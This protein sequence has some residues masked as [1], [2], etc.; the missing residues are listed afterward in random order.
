MLIRKAVKSDIEAIEQ[1]YSDIHTSEEN[2]IATIGWI[3]SV[4]PTRKTAEAALTRDDLFV[5]EDNGNIV[6]TAIINRT[7]VESYADGKWHYDVP[8][9]KVMVLHT[10]VISPAHTGQGY[11][12]SFVTFYEQYALRHN[13]PCLRMDTNARNINARALY[14]KLGYREA[15]IVPCTFNGIDGVQLVLLEKFIG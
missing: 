10:L 13:C 8:D 3:R 2:G 9:D 11:G 14:K 7:Q 15:D 4:Y 12:K 6:G 5:M 1:I